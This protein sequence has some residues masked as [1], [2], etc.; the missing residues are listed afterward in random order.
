MNDGVL[1]NDAMDFFLAV[2]MPKITVTVVACADL[3]HAIVAL[4][5]PVVIGQRLG[6]WGLEAL[7]WSWVD[8]VDKA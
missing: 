5:A 1:Y 4:D 6:R 8:G 2:A 3:H 7:A